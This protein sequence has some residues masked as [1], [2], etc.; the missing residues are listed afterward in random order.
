MLALGLIT[1]PFLPFGRNLLSQMPWLDP[2]VPLTVALVL[3]S[4]AV[5]ML[6]Q[7]RYV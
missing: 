7:A 6:L 5:H 4:P 3:V 2:V 1:L